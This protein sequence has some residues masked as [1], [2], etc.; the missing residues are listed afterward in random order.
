M[1]KVV[2]IA[3]IYMREIAK[4][5]GIPKTIVFLTEIPISN[6]TFGKGYSK[7]LGQI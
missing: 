4:F 5:D 7:D 6:Q 3:E 1:H 2:D